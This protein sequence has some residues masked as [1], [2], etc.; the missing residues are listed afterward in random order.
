MLD[1][2]K[3]GQVVSCNEVLM[4]NTSLPSAGTSKPKHQHKQDGL[5]FAHSLPES[6]IHSPLTSLPLIFAE[7]ALP[8]PDSPSAVPIRALLPVSGNTG[9]SSAFRVEPLAFK[10]VAAASFLSYF[11]PPFGSGSSLASFSAL[12]GCFFCSSPSLHAPTSKTAF[13]GSFFCVRR[14]P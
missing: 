9:F 14:K 12:F 2:W 13:S 11:S 4:P 3:V 8:L 6:S 10:S 7:L 1:K 5:F